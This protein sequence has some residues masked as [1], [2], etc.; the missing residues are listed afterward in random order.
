MGRERLAPRG[1]DGALRPPLSPLQLAEQLRDNS[2]AVTDSEAASLLHAIGVG[3]ARSLR[4]A[5]HEASSA[6]EEAPLRAA[7]L[8]W[9]RFVDVVLVLVLFALPKLVVRSFMSRGM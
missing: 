5:A 7:A 2:V 9:E 6:E 3:G 1:N 8:A 4:D